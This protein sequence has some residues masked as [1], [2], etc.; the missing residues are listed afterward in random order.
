M[1]GTSRGTTEEIHLPH[2]QRHPLSSCRP[3]YHL[4]EKDVGVF[5]GHKLIAF[6]KLCIHL[7]LGPVFHNTMDACTSLLYVVHTVDSRVPSRHIFSPVSLVWE[8]NVPK[9][10]TI[11]FS[12]TL[13]NPEWINSRRNHLNLLPHGLSAR[14]L[15]SLLSIHRCCAPYNS[16][17][18]T[19]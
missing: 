8:D 14:L 13:M 15:H 3:V 9:C 7:G 4:W 16:H 5:I 18:H 6:S 2:P 10:C 17:S 12:L 11:D 1:A 19:N